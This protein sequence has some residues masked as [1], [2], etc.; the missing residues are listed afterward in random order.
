MLHSKDELQGLCDG[1]HFT[2]GEP[3]GNEC[4]MMDLV[5]YKGERFRT[6]GRFSKGYHITFFSEHP[7]ELKRAFIR[8]ELLRYATRSSRLLICCD[9]CSSRGYDCEVIQARCL[10]ESLK[11]TNALLARRGSRTRPTVLLL[12][13]PL[14]FSKIRV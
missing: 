12:N 4:V 14:N 2:F 1:I 9:S 7:P 5:V 3:C 11:K 8:G 13:T 6:D 10:L